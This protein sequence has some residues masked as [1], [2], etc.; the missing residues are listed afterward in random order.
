MAALDEVAL[1]LSI[2]AVVI[3]FVF[4][5]IGSIITWKTYS[6]S[7]KPILDLNLIPDTDKKIIL[8]VIKLRNIGNGPALNIEVKITHLDNKYNFPIP[9][10]QKDDGVSLD[11]TN[12][13]GEALFF[14]ELLIIYYNI[15]GKKFTKIYTDKDLLQYPSIAIES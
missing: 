11:L 12:D 15:S 2:S 1:W 5:L 10:L 3:S 4:S 14:S 13:I 7:F 6:S 9:N 8:P